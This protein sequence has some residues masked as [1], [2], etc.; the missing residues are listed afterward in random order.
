MGSRT[1]LESFGVQ[2]VRAVLQMVEEARR[3]EARERTKKRFTMALGPWGGE[4][5]SESLQN[6]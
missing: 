4:W 1:P 5:T 2:V 3:D 6:F